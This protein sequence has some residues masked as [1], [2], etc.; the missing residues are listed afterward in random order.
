MAQVR[1][2]SRAARA[3]SLR[4]RF[5]L[6]GTRAAVVVAAVVAVLLAVAGTARLV[7][8]PGVV[9]ERASGASEASAVDASSGE[10]VA[11]G[12]GVTAESSVAATSARAAAAKVI[13][14]VDGAVVSPGLVELT[15]TDVRVG[16]AVEAAGGLAEDADT[17]SLN[18][19]AKVEDGMK[20]HVAAEGE[21]A[22]SSGAAEATSGAATAETG[23]TTSAD[24][25]SS[26]TTSDA[27]PGVS[28]GGLVN[29]NTADAAEL[30]TL[31]GV[32]EVTAAA[33]IEERESNGAFSSVEDIMRVSGIG[34]KKYEKI[35]DDICV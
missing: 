23:A 30:Q 18:L 32:G 10:A 27:S 26:G 20:V 21:A 6:T 24:G 33:I 9:I 19:A 25:A 7:A 15:G 29:I 16:D 13:V 12:G 22:V 28:S 8:R 31:S 14:H 11:S 17:S 2:T 1:R 5:G 34:E 4:R 3:A 35:K